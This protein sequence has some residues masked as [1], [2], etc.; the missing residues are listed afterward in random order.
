MAVKDAIDTL[1]ARL[2]PLAII[3]LTTKK[4]NQKCSIKNI[5]FADDN[6]F[7]SQCPDCFITIQELVEK[8]YLAQIS[9]SATGFY[10]TPDIFFN[11]DTGIGKPFHYFAYGMAVS[12]VIVDT[13]T[14]AHKLLRVDI[15]HDVGESLNRPIDMGQI[16][17][18][19]IQ[20]VGWVTTEEI[21]WDDKG[22]LLTYSPDTY[23]IPSVQDIPDI[24]N[25]NILENAAND[26][27]IRQSKAVGEP[28]FMLAFSVWMALRYAVSA[29]GNHKQDPDLPIP[30]T[31]EKILLAV[32]KLRKGNS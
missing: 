13:L 5:T 11:R 6:V 1:K 29:V 14:G 30:A 16:T 27:T 15:L 18:A 10:K 20:G 2:V 22:R 19:F 9:L 3:I 17:G 26:N 23:K 12:E 4:E 25:V 28:P 24:F 31:N 8:A 21:K 7:D 32:E